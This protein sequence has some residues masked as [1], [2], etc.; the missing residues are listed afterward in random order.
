MATAPPADIGMPLTDVDTPALIIDLD[1]FEAN[2]EHM[3]KNARKLGVR[4]RPH[5]KM[6]KSADIA[7]AQISRGAVDVCCR[8]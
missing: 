7:R 1:T 8:V 6:H 2:L 3:A 4:L 5:A